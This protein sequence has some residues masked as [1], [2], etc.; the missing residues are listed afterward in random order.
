MNFKRF[1]LNL[2]QLDSVGSTNNFAANLIRASKVV[3]GMTIMTKRQDFGRGQRG[4]SW[5]S[6]TDKNLIVS[7]IILPEIMVKD[8]FYLNI[9]ASLAVHKTLEDLKINAIIKW[10][11]DIL[12]GNKKIAGILIENQIQAQHINTSIVGTGLN[13]NQ[14]VFESGLKATSVLN[15]LGREILG[16]D[17][18]EQYYAYLDF[19]LD[20]LMNSNFNL[21]IK[22][23]YDRL[24]G[25]KENTLFNIDGEKVRA[26]IEGVTDTG[27][28]ML[29]FEDGAKKSFGMQE[30][31][32]ILPDG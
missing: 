18:F 2:T 28:L 5:Q 16:I 31:S 12:V 10:P 8:A 15:E 11:N 7:T 4:N 27:E 30:V 32:F 9:I 17:V 14:S 20:H 19:Y 26:T 22:R 3:N 29:I 24:Y 25:Y 23:Y 21:L 1:L 6:D 13:V